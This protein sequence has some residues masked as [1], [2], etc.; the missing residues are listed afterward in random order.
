MKKYVMDIEANGLLDTVSSIWMIVLKPLSE[1]EF[2]VFSDQAE[3]GFPLSDFPKWADENVEVLIAHNGIR[4]DLEVLYRLL[5]WEPK[6]KVHDTMIISKLTN[7][8]RPA[9]QGRHSLKFW[10]QALGEYKDDYEGGFDAYNDEMLSYCKQDCVVTEKVYINLL[11]EISE[12]NQMYKGSDKEGYFKLALQTE[13]EI[14]KLSAQQTRDGWLFDFDECEILIEEI[15]DKMLEIEE[16]VEPHLS[17]IIKT[18]D[19]EP[20]LP[21]Y[22]KN[23]EYT[24]ACANALSQYLGYLVSP[25]DAL[26]STPPIEPGT[27]FVRTET[28]PA[29]LGNQ[30]VVKQYLYTL[31]WKPD[32]WNWKKIDGQFIKMAPKFTEKSLE[33]IGHTHSDMINQYYMLRQ[34]RSVLKGWMEQKDGDGRLRGDVN[35]QGAASFRQTHRVMVNIPGARA[36]YGKEIRSLFKVPEGKTI[37]SADGSAYQIR[38]LAHYLKSDEYTDIVLN[39]DPHQ[40]HADA[41]GISR[42]LAKP[43]FFSVLFGAGAGKVGAILGTHQKDGGAKR[44]A[45][46]KGI[47][48]MT[49][50]LE[51]VKAYVGQHGWIPGI[52]GRKVYPESDYKALN[53]LIQSCEACLMKRTIVRISDRLKAEGIEAKQLLFYHDECS[54]EIDPKDTDRVTEIIKEAF[55]EA[56]KDYGVDLMEAGDIVTG[57]NYY[58]VH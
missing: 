35:D 58:E 16:A 14:S 40:R 26:R 29:T 36:P 32:E 53:Y 30:D 37:I 47:P 9:T 52:D 4:Y 54:W 21:A 25:E 50:L 11:R 43:V 15:T 1:D 44:N 18:I 39:G 19:K 27:E 12:I 56:P 49:S 6:C 28:V 8:K 20:K 2:I 34:R 45:L 57:G 5:G 22:K 13:H 38:I 46:L 33:A 7:F 51:K 55:A 31:G 42:D 23:G 10:G 48:G 3:E 41:M 17:P 24:I